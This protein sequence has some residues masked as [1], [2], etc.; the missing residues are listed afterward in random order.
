MR[1]REPI[2][3]G[4]FYPADPEAC[5]LEVERILGECSP[6]SFEHNG[7]FAGLVPHAGW[8]YSGRI[9]ARVFAH[10]AAARRPDTLVLF[11]GMHRHRGKEAAM[12]ASG[13]W[14]TPIGPVEIDERL[15]ERILGHTNL[16]ADDP[17]AHEE[18]HS[19]EVQVPFVKRLFPGAKI[20]PIMVPSTGRAHEVGEAV[21]RTIRAY[22]C[23]AV[24]AGT[25]DLTHY[26]PSYGFT[27]RG[28]GEAGLRW[29]GEENDRRFL[30][31]I[32]A[33]EADELVAEA[34]RHKNACSG[35]AAAAT[36]AAAVGLGCRQ[37]LILEHTS[38]AAVASAA[39]RASVVDAVGYAGVLFT[40]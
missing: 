24:V 18:E 27:P 38:S 16:I 20:V 1:I 14:E 25:T 37:A 9:A 12:F 6:A 13:R 7:I 32:C 30:D 33:L 10:L 22:A 19:I 40:G 39:A 31:R 15:A 28:I 4:T 36:V 5:R 21:S 29:A 35:G 2:V 11:G 8:A 3:A 34:G 23:N 17:Y 26:G